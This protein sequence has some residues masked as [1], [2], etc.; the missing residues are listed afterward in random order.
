MLGKRLPG[1]YGFFFVRLFVVFLPRVVHQFWPTNQVHRFNARFIMK[2]PSLIK[3]AAHKHNERADCITPGCVSASNISFDVGRCS[4]RL[5]GPSFVEWVFVF[6]LACGGA[7]WME[8]VNATWM[9]PSRFAD[10]NLNAI[11]RIYRTDIICMMCWGIKLECSEETIAKSLNEP[12]YAEKKRK[13]SKIFQKQLTIKRVEN[14]KKESKEAW[15]S[16][17]HNYVGLNQNEPQKF[18]KSAWVGQQFR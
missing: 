8:A 5:S 13:K 7:W 11:L 12:E 15:Q 9:W 6:C 1:V 14:G 10:D 3:L 17:I 16:S 4:A 2:T 18:K